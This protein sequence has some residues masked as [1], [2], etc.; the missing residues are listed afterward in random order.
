MHHPFF[1][2]KKLFYLLGFLLSYY[3]KYGLLNAFSMW[4]LLHYAGKPRGSLLTLNIPGEVQPIY[5]RS[6]TPDVGT[7]EHVFV[8]DDYNVELPLSPVTILDLGANIGLASRWYANKYPEAIII[9]IEPDSENFKV[10]NANCPEA[11][12]YHCIRAAVGA[13]DGFGACE[14][15]QALSHS[16]RFSTSEVATDLPIKSIKTILV[17]A[18]LNG[19]DLIKMDIEGAEEQLFADNAS[20]REWLPNTKVLAVEIHTSRARQLIIDAMP[21]SEWSHLQRGET[22][23]FIRYG[24]WR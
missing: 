4:F 9:A 6:S 24:C 19:F 2:K 21:L 23:F 7:F 18:D 11:A 13:Q 1:C 5:V 17:D 15:P 8:W 14:N 12:G 20:L 3:N 22:D 16:F 10:L